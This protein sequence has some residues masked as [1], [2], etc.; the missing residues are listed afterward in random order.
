MGL[1]IPPKV[2]GAGDLCELHLVLTR[3]LLFLFSGQP[4][5]SESEPVVYHVE[6]GLEEAGH[7][8]KNHLGEQVR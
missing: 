6:M 1:V 2:F 5:I 7:T 3:Y 8:L 4:L